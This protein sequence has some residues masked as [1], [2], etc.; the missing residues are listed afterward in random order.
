MTKGGLL[1]TRQHDPP[2]EPSFYA[3]SNLP[4]PRVIKLSVAPASDKRQCIGKRDAQMK[5]HNPQAGGTTFKD[6][7][8]DPALNDLTSI[9]HK[10]TRGSTASLTSKAC[11]LVMSGAALGDVDVLERLA[12]Y[13]QV[14]PYRLLDRWIAS[15][16]TK[17]H[18]KTVSL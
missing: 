1:Q 7:Q 8:N 3:L 13:G 4:K 17:P 11:G 2:N 15:Q 12:R 18:K 10:S 6:G 9:A 16:E 5:C 14:V